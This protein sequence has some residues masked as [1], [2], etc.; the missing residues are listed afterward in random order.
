M[1]DTA[2]PEVLGS[3]SLRGAAIAALSAADLTEK[4]ALT[5]YACRG[6]FGRR[7]GLHSPSDPPLPARPGRPERPEL[8]SPRTVKRRSVHTEAGRI[9]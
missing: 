6:W 4:L 9:A 1:N 3:P 2:F 7:L 5:D 8:V